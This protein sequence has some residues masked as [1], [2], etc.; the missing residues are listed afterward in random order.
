ME[1]QIRGKKADMSLVEEEILHLMEDAETAKK[2]AN[3]AKE[4]LA[5]VEAV[6]KTVEDSV[7]A[8]TRDNVDR[9]R[10]LDQEAAT[11]EKACERDIL[12]QYTTLLSRRN[13]LAIVGVANRICQGCYTSITPQEENKLLGGQVLNCSNCQRLI[14]LM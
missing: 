13:G 12:A 7:A 6:L 14:Y 2:A 5:K 8:A 10:T 11:A 4:T 3:E 1:H 9:L